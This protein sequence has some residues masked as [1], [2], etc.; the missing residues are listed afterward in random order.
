M[1]LRQHFNMMT[2]R[3]EA[4]DKQIMVWKMVERLWLESDEMVHSG[5]GQLFDRAENH[6]RALLMGTRGSLRNAQDGIDSRAFYREAFIRLMDAHRRLAEAYSIRRFE[7]AIE[8]D[9]QGYSIL[10]CLPTEQSS[11]LLHNETDKRFNALLGHEWAARALSPRFDSQTPTGT[12]LA[13]PSWLQELTDGDAIY[14]L[15]SSGLLVQDDTSKQVII[16]STNQPLQEA[17][18][19]FVHQLWRMIPQQCEKVTVKLV[20]RVKYLLKSGFEFLGLP[21]HQT[22]GKCWAWVTGRPFLV[23][24]LL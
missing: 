13:C 18:D 9:I 5:R 17:M 19:R 11:F 8:K 22:A 3:Q 14:E 4:N 7:M 23:D 16:A 20:S 10:C 21:Y 6:I 2:S 24:G 1:V 15:L 12:R